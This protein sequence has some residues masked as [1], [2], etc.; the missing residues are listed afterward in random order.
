MKKIAAAVALVAATGAHAA[1]IS[2]DAPINLETTEINQSLS[3]SQFDSAL[4]TLTGVEIT[5]NGRG[6]SSA[7]VEN[8]AAQAQSFRFTSTL[9]LLFTGAGL[10]DVVSIPLF[11]T[12]GFVQINTGSILDLGNVDESASSSFTVAAA[13]LGSFVGN[14]TMSLG[15]ESFVT[16]TQS[17]GGGN[18]I[19]VQNTQAGCGVSVVYTY[20]AA[21]IS[22]PVSEPG[23][24]AL[25]SLALLGLG[26]ARRRR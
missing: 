7:T 23:T 20:D 13:D 11:D 10:S 2:F 19:V 25:G 5:I 14:G 22:N 21:V 3:L 12:G 1:V 4:G 24:L 6:I 9:D 15:C 16:N 8:T 18:V 17:G 26:V